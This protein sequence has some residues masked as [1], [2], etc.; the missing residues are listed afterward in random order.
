MG[1]SSTVEISGPSIPKFEVYRNDERFWKMMSTVQEIAKKKG[2]IVFMLNCSNKL[3]SNSRKVGW[4]EIILPTITFDLI[5][6]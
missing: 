1:W 2:V 3:I 6:R 4:M 5:M